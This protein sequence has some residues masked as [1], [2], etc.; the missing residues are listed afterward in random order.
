MARQITLAPSICTS[1]FEFWAFQG[2][3]SVRLPQLITLVLFPTT[4]ASPQPFC[5]GNPTADSK[6]KNEDFQANQP[7][8]NP[9]DK[10][11]PFQ[12]LN[13]G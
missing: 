10:G 6:K 13:L 9:S 12:F 8:R 1:H 11:Y 3:R 5:D 2:I 7:K 4:R